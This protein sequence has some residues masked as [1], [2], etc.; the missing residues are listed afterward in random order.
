MKVERGKTP[1]KGDLHDR[2]YRKYAQMRAIILPLLFLTSLAWGQR[3]LDLPITL[4]LNERPLPEILQALE[5]SYPVDFYY[6]PE[7]LP[8]GPYSVRF[9]AVPLSDALAELLGPAGLSFT[10]FSS[11]ALIIAPEEELSREYSNEYYIAKYQQRETEETRQLDRLLVGDSTR[12]DPSGRATI[13][14]VVREAGSGEPLTGVTFFI[15]AINASAI[16]DIDGKYRLELPVGRHQLEVQ[17]IGYELYRPLLEVYGS[18]AVDIELE[19]KAYAIQEVVVTETGTDYNISATQIGVTQLS[20]LEIKKLPS[21]LGEPDVVKSLLTLPGITS[22]GEGASGFNVRGGA[23][24]QN[25]I[26]QDGA[27]IFNSSHVL[28][29]FSIFNADILRNVSLF[30]GNIP[31]QYGGRVS[32]VLDVEVKDADFDEFHLRGGLGIVASRLAV[33]TP[34]IAGKTSLL[35]AGRSSYSDWVLRQA[36]NYEVRNSSAYF[37]DLNAKLS[38]RLGR[39]GLLSASYYRSFDRFQYADQFGFEW[40]AELFTARYSQLIGDRISASL[41]AVYGDADNGQYDPTG[42][43]AFTLANGMTYYKIKPNLFLQLWGDHSIH[44]GASWIRY[45]GKDESI[46]PRGME[47]AVAVRSVGKDTGEEYALYLND[48]FELTSRLSFSVGLRYSYYRQLGPETQFVYQE[49]LPLSEDTL[50]DSLLFDKGQAVKT[51]DGL[52]PRFSM[53]YKI[54]AHSSAKISYNRIYQYIH[55]VS[56]TTAATPADVWQVS[57][58]YLPPQ[59]ADNFSLGYFLNLADNQWETSFELYYRHLENLVEYKDL[60]TLFLNEYLETQLL[61]GLGRAYGAELSLRRRQGRLTGQLS[62]AFS[63][64]LRQIDGNTPEESINQG[65]WFPS[66]FDQPHSLKLNMNVQ[67]NKRQTFSLNF[68]YN[69]GRP[70][71]VPIANYYLDGSSIPHY[72]DRNQ[73]R[74]PDYHRLDISYTFRRNAVRRTRYKGSLTLSVYNLYFRKNPF[75]VFFKRGLDGRVNAFRLAVLGTAFPAMT[76]NFEF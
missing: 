49:G 38:Q 8:A 70:I 44:L 27:P 75:S 15:Q 54:N 62:Y 52:E 67:V 41:V 66:N 4:E 51:Y 16:S 42:F 2:A 19:Q 25:L 74:I 26:M 48:E 28:G 73:F 14:G 71:T 46:R 53:R 1:I 39:G 7:W 43:D 5:E 29:F 34:L 58:P 13:E 12:L 36:K 6:R 45:L 55:L 63:R 47:S 33:E 64:T 40:G 21:F 35:L 72:S 11:Y 60:A 31:A 20:P 30:K 10:S 76:Y 32:S 9:R 23:I 65:D 68:T 61:S 18:G 57:T 24:D 17:S 3:P 37:Y 59:R 22:V 56:N 69:T 50:L